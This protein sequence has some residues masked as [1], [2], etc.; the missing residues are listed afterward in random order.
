MILDFIFGFCM[1]SE[2]F[3][4]RQKPVERQKRQNGRQIQKKERL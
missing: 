1:L 3:A 4:E 2:V